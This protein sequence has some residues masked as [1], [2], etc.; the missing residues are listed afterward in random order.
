[1]KPMRHFLEID[2]LEV[3]ELQLVLQLRSRKNPQECLMV[4]E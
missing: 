3:E 2:D 4:R 1:M